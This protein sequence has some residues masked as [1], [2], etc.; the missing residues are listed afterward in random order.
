MGKI[1]AEARRSRQKAY[2]QKAV[3]ASIQIA[4]VLALAAVAPN[5]LQLLGRS[6]KHNFRFN[7]QARSVLSRL[8]SKGYIRLTEKAGKKSVELTDLGQRYL[9]R[10]DLLENMRT[11]RPRR[12]DG[13]WRLVM[14]DIPERRKKDRERL[15]NVMMEAGFAI[16]QDSVWI[17]PYDCEDIVTL[18][19]IEMRLGNSVRYGILEKLE[20]DAGIRHAFGIS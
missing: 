3:L 11:K 4:G 18:L 20:N 9:Q 15:R 5:T 17:Y 1:E 6:K 19:K 14:F 8:I 2:V 7:Y 12:W 16:F 13:R 10:E